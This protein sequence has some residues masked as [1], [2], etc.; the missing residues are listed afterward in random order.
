MFYMFY[1]FYMIPYT[2]LP[3]RESGPKYRQFC[4]IAPLILYSSI[5]P[6]HPTAPPILQE[7]SSCQGSVT[8]FPPCAWSP[9]PR[10]C[11]IRR[12][13]RNVVELYIPL[14]LVARHSF[15][16]PDSAGIGA[17]LGGAA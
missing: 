3:P 7:A 6:C 4:R 14:T 11:V 13:N 10:V 8:W 16:G 9:P 2:R 17:F 15:L 12:L 1:M 5:S